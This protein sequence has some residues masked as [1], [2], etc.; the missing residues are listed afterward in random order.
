ME[1]T[2]GRHAQQ[3]HVT[4]WWQWYC[5]HP[6]HPVQH[7][8]ATHK[9]LSTEAGHTIRKG[10]VHCCTSTLWHT[11]EMTCGRQQQANKQ[12]T[13]HLEKLLGSDTAHQQ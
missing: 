2:C 10:L 8:D 9:L 13:L 7:P 6:V 12:H 3:T 5:V 11:M 1:M 4:G